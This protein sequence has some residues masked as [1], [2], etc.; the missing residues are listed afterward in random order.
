LHRLERRQ[1][2]RHR[3]GLLER[4]LSALVPD[5][6]GEL[7][8]NM[9]RPDEQPFVLRRERRLRWSQRRRTLR[10]WSSM[11]ERF[12]LLVLSARAR[13]LRKLVRRPQHQ[14]RVL[15]RQ[16][17]LQGGVCRPALRSRHCLH[18]RRV[19]LVLSVATREL[20]RPLCRSSDRPRALRC[21]DGLCRNQRG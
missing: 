16:R 6:A 3:P 1:Q 5:G 8:R 21:D 11:P 10:G 17:R 4:R 7:R 20:Q 12:L 13:Q 9:R 2:L 14:P 15:R 19:Q 18:R